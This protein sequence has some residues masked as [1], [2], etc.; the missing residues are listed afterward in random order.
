MNLTK[1]FFVK[2][3]GIPTSLSV[4]S[5]LDDNLWHDV[6]YQRRKR[7]VY[8]AVDRV[9]IQRRITGEFL[10]LDLNQGLYIGGV[11]FRQDGLVVS[12]NFTGCIENM[13]INSTNI[14]RELAI[15]EADSYYEN[16]FYT[17]FIRHTCVVSISE[18]DMEKVPMRDMLKSQHDLIS[19]SS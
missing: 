4:G 2:G 9:A 10:R 6:V 16:R 11:P 14:I 5:L 13:Y 12:Q 1:V 18:D 7:D 3:S 8:F 19:N 15:A 17:Q